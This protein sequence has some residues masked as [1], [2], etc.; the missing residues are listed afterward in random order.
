MPKK[1]SVNHPVWLGKMSQIIA[2]SYQWK[3]RIES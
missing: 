3:Q 1:Q 2:Q